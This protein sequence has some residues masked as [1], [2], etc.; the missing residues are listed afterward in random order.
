[1]VVVVLSMHRSGSSLLSSILI[2][3]GVHMGEKLLIRGKGNPYGHW[4]DLEFL[5]LNKR[6]LRE[7]GGTWR[8][9]PSPERILSVRRRF[10]PIIKSLVAKKSVRKKWGWKDPR[11][12]LTIPLYYPY[13]VSPR[14][15]RIIRERASVIRSLQRRHKAGREW[16]ILYDDYSKRA[17][18][19]LKEKPH[20]VVTYRALLDEPRVEIGRINDWIDGNGRVKEAMKRIKYG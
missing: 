19:F 14:Y 4:E 17:D 12:C 6:I 13:L 20:L 9:P 16:G 10:N 1:M 15:I 11:T 7:A 8:Y 3:L 5:N 18:V 2:D